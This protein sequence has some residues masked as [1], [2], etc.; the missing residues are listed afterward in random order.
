MR[1]TMR[2]GEARAKIGNLKNF[3][4]EKSDKSLGH[5]WHFPLFPACNDGRKRVE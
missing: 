1:P 3:E 2:R 4:S 5:L